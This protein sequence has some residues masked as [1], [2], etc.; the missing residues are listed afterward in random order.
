MFDIDKY[1]HKPFFDRECSPEPHCDPGPFHEKPRYTMTE[2]VEHTARLMRETIDRLLKFEERVKREVTDLSK[3]L[4]ADNVIFKNSMHEA[5][6]TFLMEVKNEINVFEGNVN[7]DIKLFKADIESNYSTFADSINERLIAFEQVYEEEFTTLKTSIQEQYNAFVEN[8]N[9]RIDLHNE[10]CAQAMAD[11]QRKLTTQLNTFEQTMN[12]NYENFTESVGNSLHEFKTHWE[13]VITERLAAQDGRLSDAEMYMKTNL[14]A[15]IA[16]LIG[17]MH[18]NGEFADIIEGEVF[19][20]LSTTVKSFDTK[21]VKY[22]GARGNGVDDDTAAFALAL[23]DMGNTYNVLSIPSGVYRVEHI[24]FPDGAVVFANN[25]TLKRSAHDGQA[26]VTFGNGVVVHGNLTV[27]GDK[28]NAPNET[29]CG[30]EFGEGCCT[31]GVITSHSNSKHGV[32]VGVGSTHE[33]LVSYN[34]GKTGS[35][36][37]DGKADGVYVINAFDVNINRITAHNNMRMGLTVTT[38]NPATG[39]PDNDLTGRVYIRNV[40]AHDNVYKDI[41]V[42]F[43]NGVVL[44][45]AE[46]VTSI[47]ASNSK[48]CAFRNCKAGGFYTNNGNNILVE[49]LNVHPVGSCNDVVY[50]SGDDNTI[51]NVVIHDTAAAYTGNTVVIKGQNVVDAV[52]IENGNNAF[53]CEN[54]VS[55]QGVRVDKANNRIRTVNGV[56]VP[57]NDFTIENGKLIVHFDATPAKG[58][59]GD[60]II[61]TAPVVMGNTGNKYFIE[62]WAC[63]APDVWTECRT[64]TAD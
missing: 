9:S 21:S 34:N 62:K 36:N 32:V 13:Q 4:T 38:F 46:C 1:M 53:V 25:A 60:V 26:F 10:N 63:F 23:A 15:N 17:D 49:S 55:C 40:Y 59:V 48:N 50:I 12:A 31:Y 35:A 2:E 51:A 11:Y 6:T 45:N 54:A 8:V 19:N 52:H 18:A 29:E 27:N 57:T 28:V 20:S 39:N 41:D 61:N 5:W 33:H 22:Y 64:A 3:N 24:A 14:E 42:E 16:T 7:A 43:A 56:T 58:N 44:E 37:G 30:V 47:A